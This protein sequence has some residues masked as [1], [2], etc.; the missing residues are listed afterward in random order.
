MIILRKIKREKKVQFLRDLSILLKAKI[1]LNKSLDTLIRQEKNK[2]FA[3]ILQSINQKILSGYSLSECLSKYPQTFSPLLINTIKAG[4]ASGK[5]DQ[6][7]SQ[8]ESYETRNL[9]TRKKII[10]TMIY[11]ISVLCFSMLLLTALA[12]FVIPKFQQ[13]YKG[14][15]H[16]TELPLLTELI[17]NF[18]TY[19]QESFLILGIALFVKLLATHFLM[20]QQKMREIQDYVLLKIPTIGN[21]ARN[22]NTYLFSQTLSILIASGIPILEALTLAKQTTSNSFIKKRLEIAFKEVEQG[23]SLAQSIG[24]QKVFSPIAIDMLSI[25]EETGCLINMLDQIANESNEN[26]ENTLSR[27]TSIIEPSMI[28]LLALLIGVVVIA[29]F[30]PLVGLMDNLAGF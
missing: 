11:P 16:N 3:S 14:V 23:A 22:I 20:K 18:S 28:L 15:L 19:L 2:H 30:L 24:I 7:L 9:K 10:S 5:L 1:P 4:E 25:G 27:L 8:L 29:M 17:L 13:I 26:V 12:L 21:L 6:V